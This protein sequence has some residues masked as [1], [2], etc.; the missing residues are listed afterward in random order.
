LLVKRASVRVIQRVIKWLGGKI[1]QRVLRALIA[2]W[3]PII[4][5]GAM[6]V[7][8]RQ[9]TIGMGRQAAALLER[10]IRDE[11]E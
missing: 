5:A 4:G 11:D 7:W 3:V 1:A 2:K 6:A 8:A 10:D 9:S